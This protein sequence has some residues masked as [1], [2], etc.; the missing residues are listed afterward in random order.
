MSAIFDTA[1][2]AYP[3]YE[4][5]RYIVNCTNS[6]ANVGSGGPAEVRRLLR[7]WF[8]YGGLNISESFG[9]EGIP[10]FFLMK[11]AILISLYSDVHSNLFNDLLLSRVCNQY[12][13]VADRVRTWWNTNAAP[14]VQVIDQKTG[15]VAS[16]IARW[17][18]IGGVEA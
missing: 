12:V 9:A 4:T 16:S 15:G 17:F 7:F 5:S 10:G 14:Q 8:V 13:N 1:L 6:K 2:V 3:A 11:A 18:G